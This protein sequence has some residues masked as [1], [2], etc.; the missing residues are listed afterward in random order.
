MGIQYRSSA[1]KRLLLW[2]TA[3]LFLLYAATSVV[4]GWWFLPHL[5]MHSPQFL[6]PQARRQEIRDELCDSDEHWSR[7]TVPGGEGVPLDVWRLYRP[8]SKGVAIM[9]HGIGGDAWGA[10]PQLASLADFDGVVFTFRAR[11]RLP[12]VPCTL[13]GW[14]TVDVVA[15]VQD[16]EAQGVPRGRILIVGN[17]QGGGV[18]LLALHQLEQMGPP[19]L[20]ALIESPWE[21][22]ASAVRDHLR[23]KLG[24]WEVLARPA[25]WVALRRAGRLAHF[26][27]STVS[28]V[29]AAN[30]LKTPVAIIT[31]DADVETPVEGVK[32][33]AAHLPDLTVVH[34]ARHMEAGSKLPGG[35][36][37]WARPR[38]QA[39][40]S[41]AD[42]K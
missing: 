27:P 13:G 34:D 39:W 32:A 5:L 8:E 11:D 12:E 6:V 17:S 30:G 37:G 23:L 29:R 36:E 3:S 42:R 25:E 22:L 10:A 16:L 26:D 21:N 15:V 1:I 4:V 9:L 28:P 19:L 14:E 33:I 35:W 38:I 41:A 24:A 7:S 20:G 31:G 2:I 18:A 40:L